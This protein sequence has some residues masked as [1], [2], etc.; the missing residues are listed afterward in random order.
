METAPILRRLAPDLGAPP[1]PAPW[2]AEIPAIAQVLREGWDL[3]A[4]TVLVGDNGTGKSTLVE[5]CA[6][7]SG[8]GPEGGSRGSGFSTRPSESDLWRRLVVERRAGAPRRAFFLRAETAHS[9]YTYLED[10]PGARPEP[11]FHEMSH[12][13]SFLALVG[14]RMRR[15]G[16]YLLD[17]PESAL[18]FH[19]CLALLARLHTLMASGSQ[20][21]LSTHSPVL[22]ALPGARIWELGEWGMRPCAWEDLDLVRGWRGFL[23]EP[24]RYLRQVLDGA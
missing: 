3:S 19:G 12:G 2:Y 11:V 22:A 24:A 10:N 20:V 17:E 8:T 1:I 23:D 6:L 14:E 4:A 13:E 21:I 16:L 9:F 7:A 18:S 5:A 15:P